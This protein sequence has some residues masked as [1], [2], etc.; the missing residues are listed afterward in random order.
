M[1]MV[2]Q[3]AS[4]ESRDVPTRALPT[5]SAMI[6][7][8]NN[9]LRSATDG[10]LILATAAALAMHHQRQWA[11]ED[12][13][14]DTDDISVIAQAKRQIDELNRDR[15]TLVSRIDAWVDEHL[16]VPARDSAALHTETVGS[17]IDRLAI[18]WVRAHRLGHVEDD[19]RAEAASKLALRQLGELACAYDD[20]VRD[21]L[22]GTRRLPVWRALKRY[23]AA[24]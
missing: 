3:V 15:I 7:A 5:S 1:F 16:A 2:N 12:V 6:D 11:A 9:G 14:R 13:S 19:A 21:V 10:G 24:Q 23:G 20:L 8:F 17:V 18:S 22:A 4:V